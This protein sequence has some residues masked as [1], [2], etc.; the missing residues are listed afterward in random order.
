MNKNI[1]PES[2]ILPEVE[3]NRPLYLAQFDAE[4]GRI[5]LK[6]EIEERSIVLSGEM[7]VIAQPD[8]AQGLIVEEFRRFTLA[9][10]PLDKLEGGIVLAGPANKLEFKQ[11]PDGIVD[12][13]P[14]SVVLFYPLL[15]QLDSAC[16]ESDAVFPQ[17]ER[18]RGKLNWQPEQKNEAELRTKVT[19]TLTPDEQVKRPI[20]VI[21]AVN[22]EAVLSFHLLGTQEISGPAHKSLSGCEPLGESDGNHER[23]ALMVRFVNLSMIETDLDQLGQ[24]VAQPLIDSACKVWWTKG[25]VKIVPKKPDSTEPEIVDLARLNSQAAH[26]NGRV[27]LGQETALRGMYISTKGIVEE[28]QAVE[29]YLVDQLPDRPGGGVTH[30]CGTNFAYIILEIKKALNNTYLLAHEI[31]HVLGLRHPGQPAPEPDDKCK[32]YREGSPCSVM[33][34]DK[35]NSSRNTANN[36]GVIEPQPPEVYPV[37]LPVFTTLGFKGGWKTDADQPEAIFSHLIRDFPYDDGIE[38][39][40]LQPPTT[41]WGTNSDIWNYSQGPDDLEPEKYTDGNS[42]FGDNYSPNHTPPSSTDPNYI[43][44]RLHTCKNLDHPVNVDLYL[45]DPGLPSNM[46]VPLNRHFSPPPGTPHNRLVFDPPPKPG[47]PA[48]KYFDWRWADVPA[49]IPIDGCV[50]AIAWST[51]EPSPISPPVTFEVINNLKDSD[52]DVAKRDLSVQRYLT[53]GP[54][55]FQIRLRSIP[56][57]NPLAKAAAVRLEI[58]TTQAPKLADLTLAVN[59]QSEQSIVVG[60]SIAINL[61]DSLPPNECLMLHMRAKLPPDVA[62]GD[63]FPIQLRFFIN[64]RF[65]TNYHHALQVAPLSQ[66]IAQVLDILFDAL[67]SVAVGFKSN[68]AKKLVKSVKNLAIR[69][70][71][72]PGKTVASL[73]RLA[74]RV[75]ILAQNLEPTAT[76]GELERQPVRR[77]L[78]ELA[79]HLLT[80]KNTP[81]PVFIEEVRNLAYH[82][83]EKAGPLARRL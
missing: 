69:H 30:N 4:K 23:R 44:V 12:L 56:M 37:G 26:L 10:E 81:S 76:D 36:I 42:I 61:A 54:T 65:I 33:V 68:E 15:S 49:G 55:P 82:I 78:F 50:F 53:L 59:E 80:A 71:Q 11:G 2:E 20:D 18:W 14:F 83:Q 5:I 1:Q 3:A 38:P 31:G 73:E 41:G 32:S 77:Y 21:Q 63:T 47:E 8:A 46:L 58:D 16:E 51:A 48:I 7:L 79:G 57:T 75:A 70:R 64:D 22:F 28:S 62:E 43:Y 72:N 45:V 29:I 6:G 39:S 34:P 25:G 35:P 67:R 74:R 52:N 17:L 24:K 40:V 9:S 60:K 66:T 19:L 27:A 13:D